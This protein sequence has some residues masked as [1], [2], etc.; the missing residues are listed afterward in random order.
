MDNARD[1]SIS[2]PNYMDLAHAQW[3]LKYSKFCERFLFLFVAVPLAEKWIYHCT[4][5]N[6]FNELYTC[7]TWLIQLH[8]IKLN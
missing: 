3:G 2:E 8:N 1:N 6:I 7:K 4:Y 5:S